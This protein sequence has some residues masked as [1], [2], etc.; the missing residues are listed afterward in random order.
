M[1]SR[2]PDI[3]L[4]SPL[5]YAEEIR[6]LQSRKTIVERLIHCLEEYNRLKPLDRSH[7]RAREPQPLRKPVR[8]APSHVKPSEIQLRKAS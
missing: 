6:T 1:I 3:D 2:C 4:D 5:R 8:A 7:A